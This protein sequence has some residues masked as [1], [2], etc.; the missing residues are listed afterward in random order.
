MLEKIAFMFF[1]RWKKTTLKNRG[2][3]KHKPKLVKILHTENL[4]SFK[5]IYVYLFQENISKFQ[6]NF[7]T[8]F[9]LS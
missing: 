5:K 4:K 6:I 9:S 2:V 1:W 3:D 7:R 8:R